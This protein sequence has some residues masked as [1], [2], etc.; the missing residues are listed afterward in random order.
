MRPY[1]DQDTAWA[2]NIVRVVHVE[3]PTD[4]LTE[5]ARVVVKM[6]AVVL[7]AVSPIGAVVTLI[8]GL[9]LALSGGLFGTI[10]KIIY[11]PIDGLIGTSSWLWLT[12]PI[13]RPLLLPFSAVAV[14]ST[15]YVML[16]PHESQFAKHFRLIL[17][18]EWPL[19]RMVV[20]V[21]LEF[22]AEHGATVGE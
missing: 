19:S 9:L 13:L 6:G 1:R 17:C 15:A 20:E 8:S 21:A 22:P 7:L 18:Q 3:A 10:F 11:F 2:N 16:T 14:L 5:I 4:P 12:F